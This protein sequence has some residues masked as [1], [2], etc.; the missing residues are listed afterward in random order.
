MIIP[1][2]IVYWRGEPCQHYIP[3]C[4]HCGAVLHTRA[5]ARGAAR[6]LYYHRLHV[7][8][9]LL[10]RRAERLGDVISNLRKKKG[11]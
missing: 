3:K 6:V 4:Q 2:K 11:A 1:A 9:V 8:P 5:S 10:E 7:C